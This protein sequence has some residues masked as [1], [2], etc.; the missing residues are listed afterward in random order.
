M[1][2][3]VPVT[4]DDRGGKPEDVG[5]LVGA[6][7]EKWGIADKVERARA[8]A[9]WEELV[10]EKIAQATGDVRVSGRTLFVEVKN[11][12]WLS[13]LNMM[14]HRLLERVNEGKERGRIEKIVFV[15]GDG[16]GGS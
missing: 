1:K 13:E 5:D 8:A 6:L 14:R 15:Q 9:Q 3:E 10:G 11:A 2:G 4:T 7:L 12:S 16:E